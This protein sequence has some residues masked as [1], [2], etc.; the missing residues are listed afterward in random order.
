MTARAYAT[1]T[2]CP[3]AGGFTLTESLVALAILALLIGL[4]APAVQRT[5]AAAARLGCQ[6]NLKQIALA[7]VNHAEQ[8][9]GR[10]TA[11][12]QREQHGATV[13]WFGLATDQGSVDT[14]RGPLVPYAGI[15]LAK[16]RC[17]A[18]APDRLTPVF[19]Q[20]GPGYGYSTLL[21]DR[22]AAA[23]SGERGTSVTVAFADA[24]MVPS[25]APYDRPR[26]AFFVTAPSMRFPT[27][28]FRH[29]GCAEVAFAD[30]HAE[31]RATSTKVAPVSEHPEGTALRIREVVWDL[32]AEFGDE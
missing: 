10:F 4:L 11:G 29:G 5:R 13:Y 8:N 30:G 7:L 23:I 16:L 3:R 18:L 9:Q 26:E 1:R 19:A 6:N 22:T 15:D 12:I 17:P 21:W 31:A 2:P 32:G 25:L 24:A 28:H 27:A 20:A 14:S